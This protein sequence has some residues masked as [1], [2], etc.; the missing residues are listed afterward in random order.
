M[1]RIFSGTFQARSRQDTH[2]R[3]KKHIYYTKQTE[4]L[5]LFNH[6]FG[7]NTIAILNAQSCPTDL[8]C[9]GVHTQAHQS[10]AKKTPPKQ[11][12]TTFALLKT[13]TSTYTF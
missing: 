7:N 11:N 12:K 5:H 10:H 6:F 3:M 2:K 1:P 13:F 4:E 9:N 8:W